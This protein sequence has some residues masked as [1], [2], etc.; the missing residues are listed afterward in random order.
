MCSYVY[1]AGVLKLIRWFLYVVLMR[2]VGCG[3]WVVI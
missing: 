2:D 3:A 1:E